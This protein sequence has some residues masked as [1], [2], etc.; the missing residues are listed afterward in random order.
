MRRHATSSEGNG[1][2]NGNGG[3]TTW[4]R[5]GG[6]GARLVLA[7]P[8][9]VERIQPSVPEDFAILVD[10][11]GRADLLV[12]ISRWHDL[13]I[14]G[15]A[16]HKATVGEIAARIVP[17]ED[18]T[19]LSAYRLWQGVSR[20]QLT[21]TLRDLGA[22]CDFIERLN[23]RE[24]S[25]GDGTR[26]FDARLSVWGE[27]FALSAQAAEPTAASASVVSV[28]WETGSAGL[29]RTLTVEDI[30]AGAVAF[31]NVSA[32]RD[33]HLA[34]LAG[35]ENIRCAGQ[36]SEFVARGTVQLWRRGH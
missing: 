11:S 26:T 13:G 12:S 16:P 19:A 35:G 30:I 33:A 14:D 21:V 20:R 31:G 15:D 5:F 29:L 10:P 34:S 9:D 22:D 4:V 8:V 2:A 1:V 24:R 18:G 17:R 23:M 28:V 25:R 6:R 27:R 7:V 3:H 32:P 36:Y